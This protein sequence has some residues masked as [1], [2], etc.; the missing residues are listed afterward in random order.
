MY[1]GGENEPE[2]VN[3]SVQLYPTVL[4][5]ELEKEKNEVYNKL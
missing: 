1:K 3:D 2:K 5:E 4:I